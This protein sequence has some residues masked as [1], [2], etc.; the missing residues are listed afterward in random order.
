MR[1]PEN[2]NLVE[3]REPKTQKIL[4]RNSHQPMDLKLINERLTNHW[5][6]TPDSILNDINILE[7]NSKL[8]NLP[9]NI[10]NIHKQLNEQIIEQAQKMNIPIYKKTKKA[11]SNT[12]SDDPSTD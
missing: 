6:T 3:I 9:T 11:I 2:K 5:Y 1:K 12:E 4:V 10:S 7:S 8:L